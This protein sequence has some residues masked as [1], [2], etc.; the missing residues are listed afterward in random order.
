MLAE[1]RVEQVNRPGNPGQFINP[2]T[3]FKQV[4]LFLFIRLQLAENYS[5][6]AVFLPILEQALEQRLHRWHRLLGDSGGAVQGRFQARLAE[7]P[8]A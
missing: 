1:P 3:V 8:V 4:R 2:Q 5:C 7:I 6:R